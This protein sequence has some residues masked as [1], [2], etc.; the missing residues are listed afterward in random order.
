M[1]TKDNR[2]SGTRFEQDFAD[3]LGKN[4]FWAHV[5]Q[6]NKAGQPADIIAV[7]GKFHT[8]IDCKEISDISDGFPFTRCEENQRSAMKMFTKKCN[9]LCY[10][11]LKLPVEEG[12]DPLSNIRIISM[13]RIETLENKAHK[14]LSPKMLETETWKLE[15]WLDSASVWGKDE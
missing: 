14:R 8:L 11:A 10:F 2:T 15:D 13:N 1:A 7:K 3:I 6:Q 9:E 5:M 12:N 4:G